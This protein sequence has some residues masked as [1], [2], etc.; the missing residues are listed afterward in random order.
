MRLTGGTF[1]IITFHNVLF[2]MK[3]EAGKRWNMRFP[4]ELSQGSKDR[5]HSFSSPTYYKFL[6]K[7]MV[8]KCHFIFF[9]LIPIYIIN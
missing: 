6:Q 4:T 3:A 5:N 7:F 9:I 2:L 1:G 8:S